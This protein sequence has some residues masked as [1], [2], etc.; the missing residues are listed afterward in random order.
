M[1]DG[2]EAENKYSEI[3]NFDELVRKFKQELS[4]TINDDIE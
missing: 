1:I 2:L 4:K 3:N